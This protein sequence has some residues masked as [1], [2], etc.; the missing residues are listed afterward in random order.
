MLDENRRWKVDDYFPKDYKPKQI[1]KPLDEI[2]G[3]EFVSQL[4]GVVKKGKSSG[5]IKKPTVPVSTER[6]HNF[7][8]AGV[9]LPKLEELRIFP[10][11]R[12]EEKAG[13]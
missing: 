13:L 11:N 4:K 2:F 3:K 10:L 5:L 6:E 7:E 12:Y 9:M 8:R 1:F